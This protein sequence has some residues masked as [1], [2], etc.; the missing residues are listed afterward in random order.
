[1][2]KAEPVTVKPMSLGE[3]KAARKRLKAAAFPT[4]TEEGLNIPEESLF[5][6]FCPPFDSYD[7][8]FDGFSTAEERAK[9]EEA[10]DAGAVWLDKLG[11]QAN[12][13]NSELS[14]TRLESR[15]AHRISLHRSRN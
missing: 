5:R 12:A 3:K 4:T 2:L 13:K 9:I 10:V 7:P 14:A 8:P 1:M 6:L 15:K 11:S